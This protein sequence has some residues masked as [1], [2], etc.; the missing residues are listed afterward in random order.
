[1]ALPLRSVVA[2]AALGVGQWH[3]RVVPCDALP[4][5]SRTEPPEIL[6]DRADRAL[7]AAKREGRNRVTI[8]CEQGAR[9]QPIL[10]AA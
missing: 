5:R 8:A 3:R 4:R 6:L 7:Y 10:T 9:P 2:L 1:M